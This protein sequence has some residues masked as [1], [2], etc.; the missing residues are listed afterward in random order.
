VVQLATQKTPDNLADDV[1]LMRR[2]A[3]RDPDAQREVAERLVNRVRRLT[4]A[5]VDEPCEADD[6]AQQALVEILQSAHSFTAPGHLEAWADTITVRT[7]LRT[8]RRLRMQR[9][10]IE[11]VANPERLVSF[12]SDLR[13]KEIM[14][15]QLLAYL[16]RLAEAKR[17]AFVLKHGLGHTVDEIAELTESPRG[18]V[19]DRLVAA[20][21]ELR[22]MIDRDLRSAHTGTTNRPGGERGGS[23]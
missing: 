5:L 9:S 2:V 18:T 7:T 12:V 21:K 16:E 4:M 1:S 19:K 3:G 13:R 8:R 23:N 6:A 20:R 17:E 10:M 15:R 14:P 22:R 11:Q